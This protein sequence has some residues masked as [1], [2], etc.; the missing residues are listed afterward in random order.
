MGIGR[1]LRN[2]RR[3]LPAHIDDAG[4]S[5]NNFGNDSR[6]TVEANYE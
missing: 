1:A 4:P 6:S 3:R 5:G 2:R